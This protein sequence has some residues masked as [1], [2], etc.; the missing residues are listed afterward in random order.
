M[1]PK[2]TL[3]GRGHRRTVGS[4]KKINILPYHQVS[5]NEEK[6]EKKFISPLEKP[7]RI[8]KD[9]TNQINFYS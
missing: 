2:N 5:T 8:I 7:K 4:L 9:K 3:E 6:E 1:L